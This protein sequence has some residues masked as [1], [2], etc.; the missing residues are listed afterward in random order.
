VPRQSFV[1]DS[2]FGNAQVRDD[3][4]EAGESHHD[5]GG[6]VSQSTTIQKVAIR[7]SF[8]LLD[9]IKVENKN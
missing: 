5:Q 3:G 6:S 7:S 4:N 2:P 9:V 8:V 1:R